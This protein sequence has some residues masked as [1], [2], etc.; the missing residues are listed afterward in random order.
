M[1]EAAGEVVARGEILNE[2]LLA[3][4]KGSIRSAFSELLRREADAD[5]GFVPAAF[6][7]RFEGVEV[8]L[9]DGR[10]ISFAGSIDRADLASG[11]GEESAGR[12]LQDRQAAG[13]R[14]ASSSGAGASC[15]S[16]STTAR[17]TGSSRAPR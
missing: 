10:T 9:G 8:P 4:A 16:R 12:G 6:E 7:Q 11:D 14:R 13:G 3:P 17:R 2:A 5:D 1:D 15:S